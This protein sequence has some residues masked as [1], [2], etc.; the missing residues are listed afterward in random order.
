MRFILFLPMF[1]SIRHL[2]G[3]AGLRRLA[4]ALCALGFMPQAFAQYVPSLQ[5]SPLPVEARAAFERSGLPLASV[6]VAVLPVPNQALGSVLQ[7]YGLN[8]ENAFNPASTIKLVTT[9]AALDLLG[10]DYRH[11]TRI[12]TTGTLNGNTLEGDLF[13]QGGGD[14]KLVVEDLSEIVERLRA[15][16]IHHIKG[17][18]VIDGTRFDEPEI[19]PAAFDQRPYAAYNVGPHAA[20]VNFKA[21]KISVSSEFAGRVQLQTEPR[22]D[23]RLLKNQVSVVDGGCG[24]TQ[25]TARMDTDSRILVSGVMGRRCPGTSFYVSVLDHVRFAHAAFEAAWRAAGG[26]M[27][28]ELQSGATPAHA[29]TLVDWQSPRPLLELVADINKLSNNP[30]SR[31]M[32]LNLSASS[33]QPATRQA[34]SRIIRQH[35][36]SRGLAFPELVLDNGSGL[37]RQ[38]RIS[39]LSMVRLLTYSLM[40]K[41]GQDWVSTLPLV[42]FEGTVRNRL[43]DS[44]VQGQAWIKTG[45][46]EGVRSYAGYVRSA[47]GRWVILAVIVNHPEADRARP[48]MDELLKWVHANL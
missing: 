28:V 39:A 16:G 12:A 8:A 41:D 30:M 19:D 48:G 18:F 5:L 44:P 20:M 3:P 7:G 45:S 34:S 17:R 6:G 15:I 31:Q 10:P 26:T 32:F 9:R 14:P 2:V 43:R 33:G 1:S 42:G 29:R 46:L 47:S 36:A 37:S 23:P 4:A 11:K 21:M 27:Q 22:V 40:S 25:V 38:E 35:L 24:R 13:F